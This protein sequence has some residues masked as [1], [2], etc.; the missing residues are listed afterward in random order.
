[1]KK[2]W[3]KLRPLS[4]LDQLAETFV[5]QEFICSDNFHIIQN[6]VDIKGADF[7]VAKIRRVG[8]TSAKAMATKGSFYKPFEH[9]KE[10]DVICKQINTDKTNYTFISKN[11]LEN[12]LR[13]GLYV[14]LVLFSDNS[15][16]IVTLFPSIVW[17]EPNL[18]FT[19]STGNHHE[20][21]IS[22]N[23]KTINELLSNYHFSNM[24]G[25]L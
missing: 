9:E 3:S 8:G 23:R 20:Y 7:K 10:F 15:E 6:Y 5:H 21:G 1:M 2:E 17:I 11:D 14:G 13:N 25:T 22:I 16:P 4:K 19:E 24:I 18:L 12:G